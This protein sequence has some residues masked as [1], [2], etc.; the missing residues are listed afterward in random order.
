MNNIVS[1]SDLKIGYNGNLIIE[2]VDLEINEAEFVYLV[3]KS[4][5]GKSS[6][7]KTLYADI[8]CQAQVF[9]ICGY[10]LK[11][12]KKKQVPHLRRRLGIVFQDFQLL[13]DRDVYENL[14]FILKATGWR[15]L[16]LIEKR[17][18][19]VLKLVGLENKI[20][21]F[22]YKLSGGEQQKVVIARSLLND[23]QL[24]IA[25]EPTGNLDPIC[26]NEIIELLKNISKLGTA[27]IIATHD[28][29]I[30]EKYSGK[31]YKIEDRKLI[32]FDY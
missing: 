24:I 19:E 12:I 7:L 9:N 28:Y 22:P 2:G 20:H 32:N 23:P 26:A 31:I 5:S 30:I 18:F 10:D 27:V 4:G 16:Q 15:S 1:I 29:R 21:E 6:L 3:G 13:T 14:L 17:I 8:K 11:S 25:D